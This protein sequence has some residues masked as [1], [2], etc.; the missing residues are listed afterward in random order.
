MK[1]VVILMY[2]KLPVTL[3]SFLHPGIIILVLPNGDVGPATGGRDS[4]FIA[5]TVFV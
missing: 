2:V 3:Q 1:G 4:L 5:A